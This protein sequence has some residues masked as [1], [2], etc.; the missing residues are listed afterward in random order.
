MM[1]ARV[2]ENI[3]MITPNNCSPILASCR[4]FCEIPGHLLI[5]SHWDEW[6]SLTEISSTSERLQ[7]LERLELIF[8]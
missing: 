4:F 5:D 2:D 1:R 6:A 7:V 8:F 3:Q